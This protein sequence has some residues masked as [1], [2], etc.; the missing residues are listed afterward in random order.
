MIL[1]EVE[2]PKS[3]PCAEHVMA[4][5]QTVPKLQLP[6]EDQLRLIKEGQL[7]ST[8]LNSTLTDVADAAAEAR[9][10]GHH[11]V[12]RPRPDSALHGL[13]VGED[14]IQRW[15]SCS[16]THEDHNNAASSK[17]AVDHVPQLQTRPAK[18]QASEPL[19][20]VGRQACV[21]VTQKTLPEVLKDQWA[22]Y[23]ARAAVAAAASV[24]PTQTAHASRCGRAARRNEWRHGKIYFEE[25]G[26]VCSFLIAPPGDHDAADVVDALLD[27]RFGL[28]RP[29]MLFS[30]QSAIGNYWDVAAK[31]A[32]FT[33]PSDCSEWNEK[34]LA[35][36]YRR[37]AESVLLGVCTTAVESGA[38]LIGSGRRTGGDDTG[39][40]FE[41]GVRRLIRAYPERSDEVN[42]LGFGGPCNA[43]VFA[44]ADVQLDPNL[45]P[46]STLL[47]PLTGE[48]I[49]L[50]C[51][52]V[53][54]GEEVSAWI[55]YPDVG[56]LW[57][58][59]AGRNPAETLGSLCLNPTLS[60]LLLCSDMLRSKVQDLLQHRLPSVHLFS[61]GQNYSCLDHTVERALRGTRIVVL[62]SSG[63]WANVLART[64]LERQGQLNLAAKVAGR[65]A[66]H[67]SGI[68]AARTTAAGLAHG[69]N[70]SLPS[71]VDSSKFIV[72]DLMADF[73]EEHVVEKLTNSLASIAGDD[74]RELGFANVER[75]RLLYAWDLY[76]IYML[77]SQ[78]MLFWSR[79][80]HYTFTAIALLTTV[81]A[82]LLTASSP[83]E[84]GARNLPKVGMISYERVT[85]N[86][87]QRI[88]LALSCSLL[89][90][91]SG[92]LLSLNS[93]FAPRA[94]YASLVAAAAK[95]RC[96]IYKYRSRVG[97]FRTTDFMANLHRGGGFDGHMRGTSAGVSGPLAARY[98]LPALP[99]S[100]EVSQ[101]PLLYAGQGFRE[102]VYAEASVPSTATSGGLS[103]LS[104]ARR[105]PTGPRPPHGTKPSERFAEVLNT[106]HKELKAG[107]AGM[108]AMAEPR[109]KD[110]RRLGNSL[111]H[112]WPVQTR[113]YWFLC[114]CARRCDKVTNEMIQD[115]AISHMTGDDYQR[116]RLEPL[117]AGL[118][119]RVPWLDRAGA[120]AQTMTI[121]GTAVAAALGVLTMRE[122]IPIVIAAIAA[123]DAI[124]QFEQLHG[125]MLA[126]NGA[127]AELHSVLLWWKALSSADR[128]KSANREHLICVTED[129]AGAEAMVF[130]CATRY[131]VSPRSPQPSDE[132]EDK[133]DGDYWE[134]RWN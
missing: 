88:V 22:S 109:H 37:S 7:D 18:A 58:Q 4:L 57:M 112:R 81:C 63:V 46:W 61:S 16:F 47:N 87:S 33:A 41:A 113:S 60:H 52:A 101:G 69:S 6:V 19:K 128:R 111:G 74:A 42:F 70:F 14:T 13:E 95:V 71:H 26:R 50:R 92:F 24:Q 66:A 43:E 80:A 1:A 11:E 107:D 133:A 2:G 53:P 17:G 73:P 82:V 129:V 120:V 99:E 45:C 72:L 39:G 94:K 118:K 8:L 38:W 64:V 106:I 48:L 29:E 119:A 108:G 67:R 84:A 65:G 54:L 25:T 10:S 125:R 12:G 49:D 77:N 102:T 103:Q 134:K 30:A 90:L 56:D 131:Q 79:V 21:P 9:K 104:A 85:F 36:R 117:I 127:L 122:L 32:E 89:P 28:S 23:G 93:C 20:A 35:R 86:S 44:K 75:Q 15:R 59:R 68:A 31:V 123:I 98:G 130:G 110:W 116:S 51:L 97:E 96:A 115:G 27:P 91:L 62:Q 40:L 124:A 126:N 114:H 5:T 121:L 3:R 100:L 34:D 132:V 76:L 55:R 78:K 83:S 105:R